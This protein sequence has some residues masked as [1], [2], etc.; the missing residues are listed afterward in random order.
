M[1][2]QYSRPAE[3]ALFVSQYMARHCAGD[4]G[5]PV[6]TLGDVAG[7]P[8]RFI[9]MGRKRRGEHDS[10]SGCDECEFHNHFLG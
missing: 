10:G 9:R 6:A 3:A 5:S 7:V 1:F 2:S 4:R 8:R